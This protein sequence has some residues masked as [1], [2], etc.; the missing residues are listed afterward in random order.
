MTQS[1]VIIDLG[2]SLQYSYYVDFA[3]GSLHHV[4]VNITDVSEVHTTSFNKTIKCLCI[5]SESGGD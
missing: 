1:Q 3:P 5:Y 2:F 4:K